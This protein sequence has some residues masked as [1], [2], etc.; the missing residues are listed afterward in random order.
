MTVKINT[1]DGQIE[2]TDE[3]IATVVRWSSKLRF[4]VW[5]VW[6][7]K[8]PSKI[9]FQALLGKENYSKGVV[10]KAAEDGSIAVDVYTVLSYGTKISEVSKTFKSVFVLVW[11][12]TWNYCSDCK[13]LHSKYQ[14][15][16]R[17]TVSKI[18]TSLFQEM[19][20]GCINSLE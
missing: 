2:L 4:L 11:K 18:T 5:S 20:R 9:N 13:C 8:M 1:K 14:S 15:C 6:L 10:V 12:P 17:I 7:V 16:R 19:V 3:V